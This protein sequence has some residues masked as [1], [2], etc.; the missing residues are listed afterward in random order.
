MPGGFCIGDGGAGEQ[1]EDPLGLPTVSQ[2]LEFRTC[3]FPAQRS[4]YRSRAIP[5]ESRW[6]MRLARN[7][8][9][10]S[11]LKLGPGSSQASSQQGAGGHRHAQLGSPAALAT[12]RWLIE[13]VVGCELV[14]GPYDSGDI[15]QVRTLHNKY[16]CG[17]LSWVTVP[18]PE[19][20]PCVAPGGLAPK[21]NWPAL[22]KVEEEQWPS[23]PEDDQ[24]GETNRM[25]GGVLPEACALL[26]NS[27][28]AW[29]GGA[30]Q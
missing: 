11:P 5:P 9:F 17:G 25:G 21:R 18:S 1:C 28:P 16:K 2:G 24:I 8:C 22:Q 7:T 10:S 27:G 30:A 12:S 6:P 20:P 15:C 19:L 3:D 13:R 14:E 23:L 29:G 26:S 4:H